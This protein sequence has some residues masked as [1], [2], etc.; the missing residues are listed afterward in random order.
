M[1]RQTLAHL[2]SDLAKVAVIAANVA[3]IVKERS[4]LTPSA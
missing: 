1:Q 4:L 2:L 3:M